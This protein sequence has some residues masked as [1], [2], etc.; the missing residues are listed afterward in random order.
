MLIKDPRV[1]I[2]DFGVKRNGTVR[3]LLFQLETSQSDWEEIGRLYQL[4][5]T[6]PIDHLIKKVL[7]E[8]VEYDVNLVQFPELSI[9]EKS[10]KGIQRWSK[11][12]PRCVVLAGT[13]YYSSRGQTS[14]RCPI[15]FRGE[16]YYTDKVCPAPVE[17]GLSPLQKGIVEG[18][19]VKIF[20][21]SPIGDFAVLVCAD[22]LGNEVKQLFQEHNLDF[23]LVPA[24]QG[25]SHWHLKRAE[26]DVE[27]SDGRYIVYTNN[28]MKGFFDGHSSVFGSVHR[29]VLE[30]FRKEGLR[31]GDYEREIVSILG[32]NN[33]LVLQAD[34]DHK[35]P[36]DERYP[37]DYDNV[38]LLKV[39]A[40]KVDLHRHGEAN[41]GM[42]KKTLKEQQTID[43]K[44][45]LGDYHQMVMENGL[46]SKLVLPVKADDL[47]FK[48]YSR[49]F[50][51]LL[52]EDALDAVLRNRPK[53]ELFEGLEEL[54]SGSSIERPLLVEG[55]A[56]CGKTAFL[57]IVYLKLYLTYQVKP[58]S[59][60]PYPIFISLHHYIKK[61][62]KKARSR[63]S[64]LAKKELHADVDQVFSL[65][66]SGV[67]SNVVIIV[68]GAD[69]HTYNKL[70][71]DDY[72]ASLVE[73]LSTQAKVVGLRKYGAGHN[74]SPKKD[75]K[76]PLIKPPVL[77]IRLR[78]K[79][80]TDKALSE[81]L[82]VFSEIESKQSKFSQKEIVTTFSQWINQYEIDEVDYFT[83]SLLA[84]AL[85]NEFE[86]GEVR[87][88]SELYKQHMLSRGVNLENACDL[89]F[90]FFHR[91][92]LVKQVEKNTKEWWEI[93][94]HESIRYFLVAL[95]IF[96]NLIDDRDG[97]P[98][99]FEYVYPYEV[100][101][102]LKE[103]INV[104]PNTQ[105]RVVESIQRLLDRVNITGKTHLSYL[106]GRVT[107]KHP[108]G[109]AN[110]VLRGLKDNLIKEHKNVVT[111]DS[112]EV[113]S[114]IER[115]R[116]LYLR[117]IYIS[118]TYLG[119]R[120]ASIEYIRSLLRNKYSN[121]LNRGFHLE[122]YQDIAFDPT[123]PE[124][125]ENE[126]NL[127]SFSKTF[128]RLSQKILSACD[129]RM[130]Y[131]MFQIELFTVCSLVQHRHACGKLENEMRTRTLNLIERSLNANTD[132]RDELYLFI[133][134]L[135]KNLEF[136]KSYNPAQI[137]REVY[138][139]KDELRVG[140]VERAVKAPESVAAH[141]YG[142]FIL[143]KLHLPSALKGEPDYDKQTVLDMILIHDIGEAWVGD[144]S[145]KTKTDEIKRKEELAVRFLSLA[146]T[147]DG[148]A[149][150]SEIF[151]QF[152]KFT[153]DKD[154][155]NAR[156][157]KDLDKLDNL[158]QLYIY[159]S[160]KDLTSE[161]EFEEFRDD[162]VRS[163]KTDIGKA[164]MNKVED[165]FA[166]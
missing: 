145:K 6:F 36:Y 155:I 84:H 135:K 30:S 92:D 143:G 94:R 25:K 131:S 133:V 28:L 58:K 123:S 18:E 118:L 142:A 165:L 8:A 90:L 89:A 160:R 91:P 159:Y 54:I 95:H 121:N 72:L 128:N 139:L 3:V 138:Q 42:V 80:T 129:T 15:V 75:R 140:W 87:S 104:D 76:S 141:I 74:G 38:S 24:C 158:V 105:N 44:K 61:R 32:E 41:G 101:A 37:R 34:I 120:D 78:A 63:Y 156:I 51:E 39:G 7:K 154:D 16:I 59:K 77:E 47:I 134:Y 114:P 71:L 56:G 62:Y 69:E 29:K 19:R 109:V 66:K 45:V 122:Y 67:L 166:R 150:V 57:S 132:L 112:E 86:F 144:H 60:S 85:N 117:T 12:N 119:E 113:L 111:N 93:H 149:D 152:W 14:S 108:K 163:I 20:R 5:E 124:S 103:L 27:T 102:F 13:H 33:Y 164:I 65:I 148:M 83:L 137:T 147:Y 79:P 153:H 106:L 110:E 130:F 88:T 55:V 99:V 127:A 107:N 53:T 116:L 50:S 52:D 98:K 23:W 10:L 21:N 136:G 100:N 68:D 81:L 4:K 70:E 40:I 64:T 157:A 46:K 146:G 35:R 11:A 48:R 162:L 82:A 43:A 161:D 97:N 31:T 17:K 26:I 151:N 2:V 73:G 49:L 115:K 126:D 125:L 22:N 9:P 1:E 96:R